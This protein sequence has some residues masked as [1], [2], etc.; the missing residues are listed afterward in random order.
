MKK[1]IYLTLILLIAGS[2]LFAQ[3]NGELTQM[4]N[5]WILQTWGT[6]QQRGFAQGYLLSQ[7]IMQIYQNYIF[8]ILA[9]GNPVVYN[10]IVSFYQTS[11]VVEQK[12]DQEAQGMIDGMQAAGT[13]L[14]ISALGRQLNK[15]DL[16]TFN[17]IVDLHSYFSSL[18]AIGGSAPGCASL[19]SW[20]TSTQA[21]SLLNG[22]VVISRFLDWD[23]D[24]TLIANPLMIV[25]HPSEPDEQKWISFT[26]PGMIGALSG[27]S[28]SGKS[29]FLN[30]GNVNTYNNINGLHPILFSIRNAIES[31]DY[32]NDGFDDITDVYDAVS[33]RL[34]LSGTIIHTVSEDPITLTGVIETNNSLGTVMRTVLNNDTLP[35]MHLAATNHFRL[36]SSPV[37]CTRY[38]NI[39]DS[40]TV[41]PFLSAKR[42]L[43]VLKGAAGQDNNMMAIQYIPTIET[44]LWSSATLSQ[45]AYM[46]Q[47]ITLD[48]GVL[49]G[50]NTSAAEEIQPPFSS[51]LKIYPNPARINTTITIEQTGKT[52]QTL[53]VYNLKGQKIRDIESSGD[54]YRW[55]GKTSLGKPAGAGIYLLK[56]RDSN[57][58]AK[59][60][61]LLLLN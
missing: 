38:A 24:A 7:P 8:T 39:V 36:L 51:E 45:P 17:C 32:N 42:Q 31:N 23:Q 33:A 16:L 20:G 12:Y 44:I 18:K 9:M 52:S 56:V 5:N 6:H 34:S 59:A 11:F 37:C 13:D 46:N 50:Y 47:M 53:E 15:D 26:Y 55:D 61:K 54:F 57:H 41:N 40:L 3:V 30:M 4:G 35:G 29:A 19:S 21:D 60:A 58:S 28:A 25:S 22:N 43:T 1:I 49:F 27:I 2:G 10:S 48:T 14:Y